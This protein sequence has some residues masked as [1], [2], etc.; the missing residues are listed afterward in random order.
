MSIITKK[1]LVAA[2]ILS[3][4]IAGNA[5]AANVPAGVQL[6]EKQ[7]LVRNNGSEVQS[8]DPHKIEGVPESNI[9][10]D[11]FEGLLVTDV[12]G[13]PSAGVAEKWENKD[14]KVWT[15]HLRKDAKWSNGEPVTA[16]DFVYSWQR[17]ADP[18]TASPYESYLQYGHITNIDDIIAGK[19][20]A[21]DL[22]V[23][24]IDD[25]TLEVTLSE[26]VPYFYKLLVHSSMSPLPKAV[27]EKFG[28]K[29]T[30]PA[31]IVSNGAYKLKSWVVN[32]RIVLER[33]TNYWDNAKTVI[34]E[35]TYLPI[36][37]EVTDVNRYR[38]GEIDM[39][40][41][42]M[43]IELFQKLKKEIPK[44]VHVDPY[45]CTY[46][47]EINN[48]KAPFNDPR[49]RTALKLGL[50]R[51]IIVNKV[52]NQGDLPAYGYTPPYTDGAKFTE[53][54]WFKMTQ[55]QRN[56]EAKKL[57]AEAGYTAD[58]P[59]TFDLLYNTSDLHK[60]LAIAA[61]SI[62][63]KNLG[64]NVKLENQEWKTF[65]DTRHQGNFDVARA[66]WCADY[67]EPT[68]FLNTMLSNSSN[69]TSHYK[70]DAFDKV[71]Q[72]TLQVSDEGQRSELY[73]K[74]EQQ[75]D[76]DSVIVPVYYYVN[77]R[78]VKPW[79]GGYTGKDPLDNVY[80][81]NLYIIKH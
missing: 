44:E 75:L 38:S 39:T 51:D 59:L 49:V 23:K 71:M 2:G 31:N 72:E 13:H 58:K 10:R 69:N 65:L 79:V 33:N 50:D 7:T 22:G 30:Q 81:K 37:S 45:L 62:W 67:N 9:N 1:S 18:K 4:L 16:Q 14:F 25:H 61:A 12:E 68:S 28:E 11:L 60:K 27:V 3:A 54:A 77:A 57:L 6:A 29:W 80:V 43:P 52:K 19:K 53:P 63:K 24:A 35:V 40:Y 70:S 21:T 78:L 34:N 73:N 66:G 8:L 15:F 20:P 47:Y 42:N 74:A 76:K 32:E 56:A 26:P 17:L 41:N 5:M 64:V 36:S 48:Q 55:E 46:Y